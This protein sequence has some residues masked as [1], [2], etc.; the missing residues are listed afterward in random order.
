MF[1][2]SASGVITMAIIVV[3]LPFLFFGLLIGWLF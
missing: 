2:F 1:N 3:G